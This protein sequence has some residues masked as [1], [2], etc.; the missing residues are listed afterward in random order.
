M[1]TEQRWASKAWAAILQTV[2]NEAAV[3][4]VSRQ[5]SKQAHAVTMRAAQLVPSTCMPDWHNQTA[6]DRAPLIR[7]T[8]PGRN[9]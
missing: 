5:P 7:L 4:W 1:Q 3:L 2:H 6:N 8:R 9:A